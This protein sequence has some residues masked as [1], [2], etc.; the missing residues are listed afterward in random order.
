MKKILLRCGKDPFKIIS[1]ME[2]LQKNILGTNSG[3][4][5][6]AHAMYKI[7]DT[8]DSQ[9]TPIYKHNKKQADMINDNYDFFVI[10]LANAFRKSFE[11]QLNN[12]TELIKNLKIPVIIPG[13]G[14]QSNI[15][16]DFKSLKP[17][18]KVRV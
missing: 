10:P 7:L 15:N 13:V 3:N 9:I 1:P 5:I 14:A 16:Y 4:L 6:Y 12:L 8:N 11:T 18:Y 17:L 2:T